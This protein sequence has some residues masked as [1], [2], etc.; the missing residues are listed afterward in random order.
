MASQTLFPYVLAIIINK[1][2]EVLLSYRINSEWFSHYYGLIGGKIEQNESATQ[3][4]SRELLEELGITVSAENAEF[5]HVMHFMGESHDPCIALF[6]V[7]RSWRGEI[8]N[9]E[10]HKNE[11]LEWFSFKNLPEK[12][13]PR[14]RKALTLMM[15]SNYYSED[16]WK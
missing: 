8:D 2:N 5:V 16:N 10:P 12:L 6:Y 9:K 15:K 7:I 4:F 3:A 11:K 13:I 14:H 1:N